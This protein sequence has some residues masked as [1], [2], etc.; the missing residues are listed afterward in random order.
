ML[1]AKI[2]KVGK[3]MICGMKGVGKTALLEQLIYGNVNMETEIHPTIEDIYV[4]SVDTGR[5]TRETL[6]IYDSAGLQGKAQLPRHYLYFP[7]GY[8]LVYDPTDPQS[9]DMLADI[10][11]DID[12]NKEK[13]EVPIIVLANMRARRKDTPPS[14]TQAPSAQNQADPV[15]LI[16]NR[17]NSWCSRERIKHYTVNAMERPSLYEPFINL[18]SRL[19]PPQTKSSFPQLRQVMQKTQKM[20]G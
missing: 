2:G 7:D 11:Q 13:K 18:C 6:R 5:G 16:L 20:E 12:K 19:H 9:L 15:E 14:P 4:A 10:K 17:A 8:V 3:V 1:T